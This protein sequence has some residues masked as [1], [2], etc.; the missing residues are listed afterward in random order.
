MEE[1]GSNPYKLVAYTGVFV[2]FLYALTMIP[3]IPYISIITGI[4]TM[5][6]TATEIGAIVV[7]ALG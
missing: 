5:L 3:A 1:I 7:S 4:A 6:M 2:A